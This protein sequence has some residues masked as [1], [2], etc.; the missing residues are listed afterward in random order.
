MNKVTPLQSLPYQKFLNSILIPYLT[1]IH[2]PMVSTL[3]ENLLQ[4][5]DS[6]LLPDI[7][8]QNLYVDK[9]LMYM[10]VQEPLP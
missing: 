10:K 1:V 3:L 8:I 5:Q 6:R 4:M 7:L 9:M 2:K